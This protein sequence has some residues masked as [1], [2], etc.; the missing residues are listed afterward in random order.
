M[1]KIILKSNLALGDIVMLTSAVRDLYLAHSD[2]FIIDVRT[3]FKDLWKNNPYIKP[4]NEKDDDVE[5]IE[6]GYPLVN[7]SSR[8]PYHFI[9]GYR[10][11]IEK[12]LNIV[13]PPTAF[14][15]DIHLSQEEKSSP[16][17][18]DSFGV[19]GDYWLIQAG[20]KLKGWSS[21]LWHPAFWQE[22]VDFFVGKITFVQCGVTKDYHYHTKLN[23]VVSVIDKENNLRDYINLIYHARGTLSIV[24]GLHHLNRAIPMNKD[25]RALVTIASGV[26]PTQWEAYNGQ[27][28]L[29]KSGTMPCCSNEAGCCWRTRSSVIE[30]EEFIEKKSCN[31]YSRL[32]IPSGQE[33]FIQEFR[34]A[35]CMMAITPKDVINAINSYYNSGLLKFNS[36]NNNNSVVS[37]L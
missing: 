19:N 7:Y 33:K 1:R 14:K 36:Q 11:D 26:E 34:I 23:N 18:I 12:K 2:K 10:K 21:K 4:L 28:F 15:G 27:I 13:I 17:F 25:Y 3:P 6:V 29:T 31:F 24:T 32:P 8:L 9:H 20:G 22:V 16:R 30:G 37:T 35:N 5:V